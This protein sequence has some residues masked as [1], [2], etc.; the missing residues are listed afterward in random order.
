MP[1]RF[2]VS[3]NYLQGVNEEIPHVI[4]DLAPEFA[5]NA[6]MV[7]EGGS[8]V[9]EHRVVLRG[10]GHTPRGVSENALVENPI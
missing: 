5:P 1:R 7:L 3:R 6:S 8:E 2:P 4:V 10:Q 9:G